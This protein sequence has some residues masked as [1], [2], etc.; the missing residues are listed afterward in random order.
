MARFWPNPHARLSRRA[1][2]ALSYVVLG[3]VL[4][5]AGAATYTVAAAQTAAPHRKKHAARAA[6][7]ASVPD[8]PPSAAVFAE[9]FVG[10]TNQYAKLKGDPKR[11]G[12][13]H[14]VQTS[15]D[16]TLYMC[17]YRVS[18]PGSPAK[19]YLMQ[20]RWTPDADASFTVL[21]AGRT[22]RCGSLREA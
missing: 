5:G 14:C 10:A 21:L 18:R 16:R 2:L 3:L 20:A 11:V 15:A 4:C 1:R 6:R 9:D 19:C 13:A 12:H 22:A 17:S 7:S 8:T